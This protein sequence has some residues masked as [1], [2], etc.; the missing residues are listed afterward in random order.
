MND[1][2]AIPRVRSAKRVSRTKRL[3]L[4]L[5]PHAELKDCAAAFGVRLGQARSESR[6]E[7]TKAGWRTVCHGMGTRRPAGPAPNYAHM[8]NKVRH[9]RPVAQAPM[10]KPVSRSRS[11]RRMYAPKAPERVPTFSAS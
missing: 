10:S 2:G 9:L 3:T 8:G 6:P 1:R 11:R 5:S 4:Q 7:L